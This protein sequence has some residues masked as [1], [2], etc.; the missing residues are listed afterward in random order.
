[1]NWCVTLSLVCSVYQ[2]LG[3]GQVLEAMEQHIQRFSCHSARERP[4]SAINLAT[5][6]VFFQQAMEHS[7]RLCRTLVCGRSCV[8]CSLILVIG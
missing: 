3:D 6:L 5:E 8:L 4:S 2:E 7:T 1:M